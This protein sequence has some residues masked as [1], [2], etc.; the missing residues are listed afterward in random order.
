MNINITP[1]TAPQWFKLLPEPYG[2]KAL[3][4]LKQAKSTRTYSSLQ[5]AIG[6]AFVW[7]DTDEKTQGF[8]YWKKVFNDVKE[9]RI[10][11][12]EEAK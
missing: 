4:N 11:L 5:Q 6:E 1:L 9:G 3:K 10:K 12:K 2:N 7:G 8:F